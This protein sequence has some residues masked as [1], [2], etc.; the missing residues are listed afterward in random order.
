[1]SRAARRLRV[2][3]PKPADYRDLRRS[4]RGDVAAGLTVG[5][6]ALP[7]ALA[8]GVSSGAGAEA[9]LV[10]AI[11]AGIVAAVFGGSSVQVSGPTGAMVVVLAPIVA[12][13]GIGSVA[14]VSLM[15]GVI[16]V[17]A[18]AL[19]LG[20]AV[21]TIPWPVI[22][23]F[24]AGIGITIFLQQ[25]PAAIGV[26][27]SGHSTNAAVAAVQAI[28]EA[29]WPGALLPIA[30]VA[31]VALIMLGFGRFAP[32]MPGSFVAIVVV[33]LVAVFAGLGLKEIGE[34]PASLPV[35]MLPAINGSLLVELAGPACAVAALA[36]I[37]SLLSARVAA[38]LA[39]TGPVNADRELVGQGLA[40]IA[41]SFFGGMPA[42]GAIARTA[43]NVRSG[44]R[45]R[46]AA[47][48]HSL[49]LLFVVVAA[50]G[51]VSSIPLAALAGVLMMTAARMVSISTARRVIM[52]SRST[53]TIYFVTML[54]TVSFDLII[55]V[56]IGLAA[57]GFFALRALSRASG[58]HREPLPGEAQ[59]GDNRI[60]LF[61]FDGSLFFGAA[62]RLS[63]RIAEEPNVQ[64]VILRLS[65]LQLVD[66]TGAHAM[67]GLVREL[68]RRGVTVLIKGVR[69]EHR[70]LMEKL[71]VMKAL[72]HPNHLFAGLAPALEHAR[73]HVAR[74]AKA[75]AEDS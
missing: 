64:V 34:L 2:L 21:S 14:I 63:D 42:T 8:F 15:A 37:E 36:A 41:S 27:N 13:H 7:L 45:T 75:N 57:A 20:R 24:T 51:I 11:V 30:A 31:A 60:A 29:S 50:A 23:G 72:R 56:G 61:R 55:A 48:V 5:I 67:A 73:S 38:T 35:P 70:A 9:G 26:H 59:P 54:V 28:A 65:Q 44:G 25:V 39:D 62:E 22:E 3:L 58:A 40:S 32:R 17:V 49:V 47:V 19:R 16:V 10:T 4:W 18:G 6:V 66:S 1:M 53:A 68:E 74:L 69:E 33:S 71:G 46:L 12:V 52:A 43:V